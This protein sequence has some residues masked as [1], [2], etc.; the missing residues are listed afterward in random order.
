MPGGGYIEHIKDRGIR[1]Q[2]PGRELEKKQNQGFAG[3]PS[4]N[5]NFIVHAR[6]L[7]KVVDSFGFE[8]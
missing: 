2:L 1:A 3:E 8:F 5:S 6:D 7:G 4:I